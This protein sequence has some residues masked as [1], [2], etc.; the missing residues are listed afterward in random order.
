MTPEQESRTHA[1]LGF[2]DV[3]EGKE[4]RDKE[5]GSEMRKKCDARRLDPWL[6]NTTKCQDLNRFLS[7]A[8]ELQPQIL[9]GLYA[10]L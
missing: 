8:P 6:P 2:C 7:L 5:Q 9:P 4:L 3:T 1:P 10:S